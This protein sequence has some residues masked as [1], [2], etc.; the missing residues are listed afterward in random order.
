MSMPFPFLLLFAAL[1][2]P[3]GAQAAPP[4]DALALLNEVSQR[5]A[6][7]KSYHLEGS[8][9]TTESNDLPRRWD[10]RL[11]TA[12]VESDGRYRYEG[13][14][15]FGSA[16][17]VSDGSTHWDYHPV[18]HLYTAQP[19][20]PNDPAPGQILTAEEVTTSNAKSLMNQLAREADRAKSPAFL[21]NE[22]I[23][24]NGK[25]VDCYV[26]HYLDDSQHSDIRF[27]WTLWIDKSRKVIAKTFKRGET[28]VLTMAQGRLP[29]HSETAVTYPVVELD[30]KEP[31]SSF[32][33]VAPADAKLVPEFPN[34]FAKKPE[35]A[36]AV[37]LVGKPAPELQ[38]AASDGRVIQLSSFRGKPLFS[39]F[40]A[41]WCG[42]CVDLMPGLTKLYAE[43]A[44]KGLA[45]VSIDNDE[46]GKAVAALLSHEHISWP[47]YHDEYNS[48]GKA[49]HRVGIPLGVLLDADGKVT[50][51]QTGYGIGDLRA[52]IAKLGPEFSAVASGSANAA[53]S[54]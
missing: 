48:F 45:W 4:K 9:K 53:P 50:F 29:R 30:Q 17:L 28:Y 2:L 41:T 40:W 27:E 44:D 38:L 34:S 42:P 24:V 31:A 5:Y 37:D 35:P 22:T 47:N 7:A 21:P 25:S 8:K 11:L 20:S 23:T 19:A 14:S 32:S 52:A 54:K 12:T 6:D 26:V 16:T 46:D 49:F 51:Y 33:F 43:T 18:D 39:E 1:A 36:T 3:H 10:K 15:G 13:V